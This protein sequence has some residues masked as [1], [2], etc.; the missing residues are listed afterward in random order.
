MAMYFSQCV[1]NS[2]KPVNPYLLHE[3]IWRLFPG[4]DDEKRTFLFR[5]ENLGQRGVQHILLQSSCQPQPADGDLLL[6]KSKEIKLDS[7]QNGRSYK[8]LLRANPTKKIKDI[9]GKTT[10]QGKVRVPIID[11]EEIFAWLN[12]QFDGIAEIN[13]VTLAQ[14]DLLYFNKDKGG[15]KHIGKIQTVTFS[16]ILTVTKV[17][18][19]VNR[20]KEGFGTAKAFGC[21]LLT[22]AII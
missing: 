13:A 16:G 10:N 12:R 3:K 11:E 18:L 5:V 7:I 4:K 22:L 19:L 15:Q 6:L 21:G 1:L 8:F 2:V 20:I 17:E 9:G 14:Q